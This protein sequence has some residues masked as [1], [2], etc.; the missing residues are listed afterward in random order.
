MTNFEHQKEMLKFGFYPPQRSTEFR[1]I[2]KSMT[3]KRNNKSTT[4]STWPL[5][6]RYIM[7]DALSH[8][9]ETIQGRRSISNVAG[10][11][12]ALGGNALKFVLDPASWLLDLTAATKIQKRNVQRK[13]ARWQ[14]RIK[15]KTNGKILKDKTQ[16]RQRE[17]S[18]IISHLNKSSGNRNKTQETSHST[19]H[20]HKRRRRDQNK[21]K[22]D[23]LLVNRVSFPLG[24]WQQTVQLRAHFGEDGFH[25]I[26]VR[27]R[28]L[29]QRAALNTIYGAETR[30][31]G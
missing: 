2:R 8:T 27:L 6:L 11:F 21:V 17:S 26:T 14:E 23:H 9:A 30:K 20:Q 25:C 24:R 10:A 29:A 4:V 3:R 18:S 7:M 1:T 28:N 15:G 31:A 12:V 16:E 19:T 13:V 5:H 22:T